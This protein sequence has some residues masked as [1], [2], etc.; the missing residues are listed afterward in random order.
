MD[1]ENKSP[2]DREEPKHTDGQR[3]PTPLRTRVFAML[4]VIFMILLV[5]GYT[6]S[7]AT[8]KIFAF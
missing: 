6:Y 7:I 5:I 2:L 8:G 1:Q 3:P 4:G